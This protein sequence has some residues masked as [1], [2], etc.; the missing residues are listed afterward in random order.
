MNKIFTHGERTHNVGL[1]LLPLISAL[2]EK[3]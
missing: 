1:T 2:K 3:I